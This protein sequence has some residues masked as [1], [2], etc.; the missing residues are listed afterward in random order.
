[1]FRVLRDLSLRIP[2]IW[3]L[4]ISISN[5]GFYITEEV[6]TVFCQFQ[7]LVTLSIF[8]PQS[9]KL[10]KIFTFP[11]TNIFMEMTVP[12]KKPIIKPVGRVLLPSWFN[13]PVGQLVQLTQLKTIHPV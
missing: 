8:L 13:S 12:V 2:V 6:S 1:V 11:F 4:T 9:M 10:Y 7:E 5:T 3:I